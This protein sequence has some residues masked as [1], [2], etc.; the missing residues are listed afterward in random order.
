MGLAKPHI[1]DEPAEDEMV[2]VEESEQPAQRPEEL[3]LIE[4]LLFAAGD[5]RSAMIATFSSCCGMETR[6]GVSLEA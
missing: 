3:R 2:A 1:A 6:S 4:A 5:S